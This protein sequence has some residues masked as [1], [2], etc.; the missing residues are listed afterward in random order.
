MI[1]PAFCLSENA[2]ILE[3]HKQLLLSSCMLGDLLDASP[4]AVDSRIAGRAHAIRFI[5]LG[6]RRRVESSFPLSRA[7]HRALRHRSIWYNAVQPAFSKK[8]AKVRPRFDLH[9]K[10]IITLRG[11][12][13]RSICAPFVHAA[14]MRFPT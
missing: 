7:I 6:D 11:T 9:A 8:Q 3:T 12:S 13:R 4:T 10:H 2:I 5:E 14:N 1:W